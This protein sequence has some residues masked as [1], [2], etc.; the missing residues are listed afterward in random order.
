MFKTKIKLSILFAL[1]ILVLFQSVTA[2]SSRDYLKTKLRI[3]Y[4][5]HPNTSPVEQILLDNQSI[6]SGTELPLGALGTGSTM[7]RMVK[8][9]LAPAG[10]GGD[11]NFQMYAAEVIKIINKPVEIFLLNDLGTPLNDYAQT[12][13]GFCPDGDNYA[14]PCASNISNDGSTPQATAGYMLLGEQN[15]RLLGLSNSKATFLHEL[16]HTQDQ[17]DSRGHIWEVN[18]Q[19]FRYGAD[20]DHFYTEATPNIAMSY[21][22]GIANTIAFLYS[23]S[24][25]N[26]AI[27][28]FAENQILFVETTRPDESLRIRLSPDAWLYD[29]M[30]LTTPPGPGIIVNDPNIR[31]I[32][33]TNYRGYK[34]RDIPPRFIMHNEQI[35]ALICTEYAQ[36]TGFSTYMNALKRSNNQLFRVSAGGLAILFTNLCEAGVPAGQSVQSVTTSSTPGPKTY[37]L[38]LALADYYTGYRAQNAAEFKAMFENLLSDQW[39]NAYWTLAKDLIRTAAPIG[40]DQTLNVQAQVTAIVAALGIRN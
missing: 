19:D 23:A 39:V 18:D 7:G 17:A 22:E 15:L 6:F 35:I 2:Q 34:I 26:D 12:N 9:I 36:R 27:R 32:L 29:L 3:Y 4:V 20:G 38:P 24:S 10:S 16:V 40:S 25:K 11:A 31:E 8:A 13:Y 37:L 33:R 1:T 5:P 21:T 14:W 28:W 30:R